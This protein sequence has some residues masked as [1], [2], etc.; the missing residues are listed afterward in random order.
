MVSLND[1]FRMSLKCDFDLGT[2]ATELRHAMAFV[3]ANSWQWRKS[4]KFLISGRKSG[5]ARNLIQAACK[6]FD[7]AKREIERI[8]DLRDQSIT[9]NH[10]LHH[11]FA[12]EMPAYIGHRP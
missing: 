4:T 2:L 11:A 5:R 12:L 9:K 1:Q 8:S 10:W 3:A 6:A 7:P